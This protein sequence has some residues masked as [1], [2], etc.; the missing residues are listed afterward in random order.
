MKIARSLITSTSNR[1]PSWLAK[2]P[3]NG[4]A[5]GFEVNSDQPIAANLQSLSLEDGL[6]ARDDTTSA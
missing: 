5:L 6:A 1:N 3:E 4:L 2:S